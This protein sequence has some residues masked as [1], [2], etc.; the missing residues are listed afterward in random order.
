[1]PDTTG[2]T[3]LLFAAAEVSMLQGLCESMALDRLKPRRRKQDVLKGLQGCKIFHFA[4]HAETDRDPA[5]NGLI[6]E[7]GTLTVAAL[8]EKH[9]REYSPILAYLSACGTGQTG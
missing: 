3:K 1:M 9:L 8:L 7:D 5:Q 6:L 4:G 2:H